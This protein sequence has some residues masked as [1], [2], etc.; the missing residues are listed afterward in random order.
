L[1]IAQLKLHK[2]TIA[3][4]GQ[5]MVEYIVV[6]VFGVMLLTTGPGGDVLLDLLAVLN[7]NHQG[8]SYATSLSTLPD[9][10]NAGDYLTEVTAL[11]TKLTEMANISF[12]DLVADAIPAMPTETEIIAEGV[13]SILSF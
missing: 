4:A 13:S 7:D 10:D 2:N 8:Y 3:Q 11:N 9:Y 1:T 6:L 12:D 5:G